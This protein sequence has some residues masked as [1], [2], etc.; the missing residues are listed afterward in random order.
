MKITCAQEGFDFRKYKS[1]LNV[2]LYSNTTGS[3]IGSIGGTI[4]YH[5]AKKK[6]VPT[7]R[8][9]DFL[10][11]ALAVISADSAGSR[12]TSPDGWT[13]SFDLTVSVEDAKFWN[14]EKEKLEELLEFLTTDQWN[15]KFVGGGKVDVPIKKPAYPQEDCVCLLSGGLDSL[16]G[17][18][19]LAH[20]GKRPYAVSQ[21]VTADTDTQT[22]FAST[23]NDGLSLFQVNHNVRV[24]LKERPQTQR[25]RSIIF[26]AYGVLVA[27]CLA[28]YKAGNT[29][30][31]YV[32]EN[33]FISINPPLTSNRVGSLTTR[34]THPVVIKILQT[35]LSDAE[36]NVT[37]FNPYQLKTKGEMLK[38]CKDQALLKKLVY[39]S[40]S[41]GRHLVN[42]IDGEYVHCGRCVPC[43]VRRS[44]L[45]HWTKSPDKTIYFYD[46]LSK[47]DKD[48]AHFDDVRAA[49]MAIAES[50]DIG[51]KKWLGASLSSSLI[52]NK[53]DIEN[54]I[55]R[56]LV[57]IKKFLKTKVS[58]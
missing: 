33:G 44:A 32:C 5:I 49:L 10:S 7:P 51:I 13:R 28:M 4:K 1:D 58:T 47:Q 29:I 27:S 23:I 39:K 42:K 3:G 41:C 8:A 22:D 36:L 37:V 11:I 57:E 31:L 56:S 15:L 55:G 19:D 26:M 43:I 18:I 20:E 24:P 17:A 46:D 48:H 21:I 53:D 12:K 38:E 40:T 54:M 9:W 2:K 35:I 34:T 52:D 50:K 16:I 6:L 14:K 45:R 30:T 25:A